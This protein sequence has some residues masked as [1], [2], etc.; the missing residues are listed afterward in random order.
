MRETVG[1]KTYFRGHFSKTVLSP[2][3]PPQLVKE[4]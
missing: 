1:I 4:K 2:P 3:L